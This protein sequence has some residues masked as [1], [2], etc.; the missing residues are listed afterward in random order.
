MQPILSRWQDWLRHEKRVAAHTFD[1]Y[2]SDVNA[3]LNFMAGYRDEAL[4]P[5]QLAA[6]ELKDF[7]AWL[8]ARHAQD[9]TVTST[10]RALSALKNFFRYLE[11]FEQISN[12]AIVHVKAAKLPK[13]LPK[14]LEPHQSAAL[15]SALHEEEE[16][17]LQA[18]DV[19]L[20][21]LIYGCGLRISEALNLTVGEVTGREMLTIQGK[22][23]KQRLVPL[24]PAVRKALAEYIALCPATSTPRAPLF[25]GVRGKKLQAGVV[26]KKMREVRRALGLPESVTPHALRHSFATHLLQDG[27]DLR[28]IQELL[29]HSSLS[30]TQRYTKV[31]TDRLLNLYRGAHPRK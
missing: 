25:V 13:S 31:D 8:A 9:F 29:G 15:I 24:L 22:G 16:P 21:T 28:A 14:A 20:I 7:R 2:S 26:Q 4:T 3:F 12:E 10:A 23:N 5:P 1:G 18:R 11:R 30:T 17:W 27:A 6:L 19:A